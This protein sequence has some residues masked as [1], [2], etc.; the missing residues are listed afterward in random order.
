MAPPTGLDPLELTLC[1]AIHR[2]GGADELVVLRIVGMHAL[3][4]YVLVGCTPHDVHGLVLGTLVI[5]C[6]LG[7]HG[8]VG[9]GAEGL[10]NIV[11]KLATR[12]IKTCRH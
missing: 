7:C 10:N 11:F 12:R 9:V 4:A 2:A 5:Y 3:G 6:I 8:V 1:V